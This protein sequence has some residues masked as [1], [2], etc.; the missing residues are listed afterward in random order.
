MALSYMLLF[1]TGLIL[2]TGTIIYNIL[3]NIFFSPLRQFP[4]P[5]LNAASSLPYD[6]ACANGSALRV[7]TKLHDQ[8]GSVVR[9]RPN[10]LSYLEGYT[11]K[12]AY[13]FRSGHAEWFKGD[14]FS[15]PN[16]APGILGAPKEDH[17]RLRRSLAHVFS[18]Q[19]LRDQSPRILLYADMLMNALAK[20]AQSGPVDVVKWFSWTTTDVIGDLA[21]GE[22]FGALKDEK[23]HEWMSL[24]FKLLRPAVMI[25]ILERW[26][27]IALAA[28]LLPSDILRGVQENAKYISEKLQKRLAHGKDRGDFFDRLLKN[29]LIVDSDKEFRHTVD[30]QEGFTVAE[31]ESSAQDLVFAGSETTAT[32]LSGTIY[33]LLRNPRVL[34][35]VTAEVRTTFAKDEDIT[36]AST[37]PNFLPYMDA[38]LSESIRIYDPVPT[39]APRVA[40]K[41]G[42]T[43]NG[44]FLPEGT[45]VTVSKYISNRSSINFAKPLEFIPERWYPKGQGRPPEFDDDNATGSYQPFSYGSRNCVGMNLAKAE[46]HLILAKLLWRFD[47]C[48]PKMTDKEQH[49]WDHWVER[50]DVWFL[51]IK[52]PL[53]VDLKARQ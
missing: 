52:P 53:F 50:Q 38:V 35:Q 27:I 2:G 49:E 40:P 3:Y 29:G 17:R 37:Q 19:G 13:G 44:V 42:D 46:M 30:G 20:H 45:R 36:V 43:I 12:D 6:I 34:D 51:W 9:T 16:G 25:G 15:Y 48:I 33:Y 18:T 4:G 10:E 23:Q 1:K 26:H 47:P 39:F 24:S 32:L 8:Y 7:L 31:L 28:I 21:F 22:A 11:W 41:G 5:L 14:S